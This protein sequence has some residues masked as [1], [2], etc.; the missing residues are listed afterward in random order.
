MDELR[1]GNPMVAGEVIIV[2]IERCFIQSVT[3]DMGCW[4]SGLK[5]PFAIIVCDAIGIRAFDMEAIEIS[6]EFLI[7]KIP[8]LGSVLAFS[9]QKQGGRKNFQATPPDNLF[10]IDLSLICTTGG[11]KAFLG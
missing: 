4:L 6:V 2:P 5:E 1:A 11:G 10:L 9:T 7:Q 8:D 3:G